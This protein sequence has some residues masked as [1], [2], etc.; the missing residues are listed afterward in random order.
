MESREVRL[1]TQVGHKAL[2]QILACPQLVQLLARFAIK[3][4]RVAGA[5]P[6]IA[7]RRALMP[8]WPRSRGSNNRVIAEHTKLTVRL[9]IGYEATL[10]T[11]GC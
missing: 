6:R 1:F 8:L 2:R 10:S 4:P 11:L 3:I 9:P 5:S 7:L